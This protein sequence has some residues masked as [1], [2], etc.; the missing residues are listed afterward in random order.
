MW[1]V[2]RVDENRTR[3]ARHCDRR[4][5]ESTTLAAM[6]FRMPRVTVRPGTGGRV[7]QGAAAIAAA[8][9][10]RT[11][12][13]R[14]Y[15]PLHAAV[16]TRQLRFGHRCMDARAAGVCAVPVCRHAGVCAAAMLTAASSA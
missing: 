5:H 6:K 16:D 1:P 15:V 3:I 8:H 13:E 2:P 12:H 4:D 14:A 10:A 9:V 7:R 11:R